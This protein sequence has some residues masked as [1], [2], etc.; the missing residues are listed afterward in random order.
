[1]S[2]QQQ[3]QS[4]PDGAM[5]AAIQKRMKRNQVDPNASPNYSGTPTPYAF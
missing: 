3:Q 5:M 1:M 2:K 4:Q